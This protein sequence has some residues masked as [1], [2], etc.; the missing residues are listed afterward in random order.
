M[1]AAEAWT[2]ITEQLDQELPD[3]TFGMWIAPLEAVAIEDRRLVITGPKQI[4]EHVRRQW[5][6]A[7][8]ERAKALGLAGVSAR[9][10][11]GT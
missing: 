11:E 10:K 4:V 1:T 3:A 7:I 5:A 8:R 9:I 6:D 2:E